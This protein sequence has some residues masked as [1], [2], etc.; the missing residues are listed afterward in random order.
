VNYSERGSIYFDGLNT[1]L[2]LEFSAF[3]NLVPEF[4][5]VS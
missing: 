4:S 1:L 3:L 5:F 2:V